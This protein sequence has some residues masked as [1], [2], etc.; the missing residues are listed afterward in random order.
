MSLCRASPTKCPPKWDP[1]SLDILDAVS[2][3]RPL[4][5]TLTR[6]MDRTSAE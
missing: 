5:I 4:D 1:F 3:Q 6:R 2:P